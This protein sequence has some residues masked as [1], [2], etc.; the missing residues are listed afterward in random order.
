MRTPLAWANVVSNKTRTAASLSGVT[1]AIL[2]LFMQLGFYDVCFRSSTMIYDQLEFDVA[3]VS[4]QYAHLR[5][6]NTIPRLRIYQ[7]KTVAGV[8]KAVPLYVN[9]GLFR[10]P[11]ARSQ[12]EV[13]VLGVVP[14]DDPFALPEIRAILPRLQKDDTAIMDVRTGAGYDRV[15]PGTMTELDNRRIELV[16][17]YAYGSGFI[18]DASIVI[19]DRT[20]SRVY[21][22][23]RGQVSIGLVKLEPGADAESV[24]RQLREVLPSDVKVW[25]REDLE[26]SEQY[27]FVRQRPLGIMFSSGV[28]LAFVVGAVILYQVL[29]SEI[30]NKLKE[31]ATLKAM[32]YTNRYMNLVVLQQANFFVLLGFVPAALMAVAMYRATQI[33]TNLPMG[34]TWTRVVFVLVLSLAMS[35][36]S[37][38]LVSLKV[39]RTDPAELF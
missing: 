8:A 31:Y 13:V 17:T 25:K 14:E 4:P 9:N 21:G 5:A 20:L 2:L 15:T 29:S 6:A 23:P 24:V 18:S 32:G 34:M 30:T 3:L 39:A 26:A 28:L 16:G 37:G 22:N 7:A 33:A 35:S 1:F 19:S 36:A 10:N 27:F 12:R 38:L 11:E